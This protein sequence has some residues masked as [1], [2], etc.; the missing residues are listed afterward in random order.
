M[1]PEEIEEFAAQEASFREVKWFKIEALLLIFVV[2]VAGS[3]LP[4]R[5][6]T[7]GNAWLRYS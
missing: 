6:K 4:L 1:R 3:L 2:A 7:A 5:F